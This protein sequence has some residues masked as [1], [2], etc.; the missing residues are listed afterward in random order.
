MNETEVIHIVCSFYFITLPWLTNHSDLG[1]VIIPNS[2]IFELYV[3]LSDIIGFHL[4]LEN[5]LTSLINGF[6]GH[7][8]KVNFLEVATC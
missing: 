7:S 5:G 6:I 8:L 4:S 2:R 1:S 3:F